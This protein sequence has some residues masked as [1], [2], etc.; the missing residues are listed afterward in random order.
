MIHYGYYLGLS[1]LGNC[2]WFSW[3]C[4]Q[5]MLGIHIPNTFPTPSYQVRNMTFAFFKFPFY[6]SLILHLDVDPRLWMKY[7]PKR[8]VWGEVWVEFWPCH[9]SYVSRVFEWGHQCSC[10]GNIWYTINEVSFPDFYVYNNQI[11]HIQIYLWHY[12]N[13]TFKPTENSAV[14]WNLTHCFKPLTLNELLSFNF[15]AVQP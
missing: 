11:Y 15:P 3:C 13:S 7:V 10:S 5:Y 1:W 2:W 6:Y 8:G 9:F 4:S 14:S 12:P